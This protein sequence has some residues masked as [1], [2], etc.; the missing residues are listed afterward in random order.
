MCSFS[1]EGEHQQKERDELSSIFHVCCANYAKVL[2][3][4]SGPQ[5]ITVNM[6]ESYYSQID[7][8]ELGYAILRIASVYSKLKPYTGH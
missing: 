2:V 4:H 7:F 5:F 3:R 8:P 6:G 1:R